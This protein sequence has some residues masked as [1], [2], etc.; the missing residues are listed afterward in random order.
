MNT[1]MKKVFLILVAL[2]F[3]G[4]SYGQT[5]SYDGP[6]PEFMGEALLVKASGET[7]SLPTETPTTK[8][9]ANAAL[10]LTGL[11]SVK[12]K[13]VLEGT[14][15][16][17]AVE[18]GEEFYVVVRGESNNYSPSAYIRVFKFD[19]QGKR[20]TA[21]VAKL[22]SFSGHSENNLNYIPFQARKYGE[23]SYLIK[24]QD[25]SA[26]E[27]GIKI[28]AETDVISTFSVQPKEEVMV[29]DS[30]DAP[31]KKKEKKKKNKKK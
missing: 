10:F 11:G 5:F 3:A 21:E 8:T 12:T 16:S 17:V 4:I 24:L 28:D 22:G 18:S 23:S 26:G 1:K 31:Q 27:Y 7:Q 29:A 2:L 15:S 6:E 20:R 25:V 13:L 30:D 14:T 9:K 19:I